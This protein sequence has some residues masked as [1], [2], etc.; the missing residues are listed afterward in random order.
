[1]RSAL[2]GVAA[3]LLV[4]VLSNVC[5]VQARAGPDID[6]GGRERVL[7]FNGADLW[8][9][10]AFTHGGALLS[11]RG[12]DE[13]GFVFKIAFGSG[14]YRYHSG[15]LGGEVTGRQFTA[16]ALPGWRFKRGRFTLT[17]FAGLEIQQHRLS[18][19]DPE[20][21]LRGTKAGLRG[22]FELWYEPTRATMIAAD[23]SATTIG[24]SHSG[25][26]A[27]GWR[28]FDRFYFGP[29]IAG[30]TYDD[31]YRQLRLGLHLTGLR[32]AP[33]NLG[34]FEWTLGAG[35]ARD[36]DDRESLYARFGM[37]LRTNFAY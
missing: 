22:G 29:E 21:K 35:W 18:P 8:R 28:L 37:I 11:A 27:F 4:A 9:H 24:P 26:L 13:D 16:S 12:L 30:F 25:R 31:N 34:P 33:F 6:L 10:G 5:V 19:N 20:S 3:A 15:A 32:L 1:M 7:F 2:G 14:I 23:L 17:G 36:S